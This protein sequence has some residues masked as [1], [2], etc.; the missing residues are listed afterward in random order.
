MLNKERVTIVD[1]RLVSFTPSCD[2][3]RTD[4]KTH[5]GNLWKFNGVWS[6]SDVDGDV[7]KEVRGGFLADEVPLHT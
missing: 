7:N 5:T 2:V 3:F 4:L 6:D 1:E